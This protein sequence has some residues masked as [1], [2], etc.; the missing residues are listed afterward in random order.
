[1]KA[2]MTTDLIVGLVIEEKGAQ[3][4]WPFRIGM[5]LP[6]LNVLEGL[7]PFDRFKADWVLFISST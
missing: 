2:E 7:I 6:F 5:T 4:H 1:M 3:I